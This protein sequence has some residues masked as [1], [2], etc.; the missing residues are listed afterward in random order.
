MPIKKFE[1]VPLWK[2]QNNPPFRPHHIIGAFGRVKQVDSPSCQFRTDC[3]NGA[4]RRGILQP[5]RL[6]FHHTNRSDVD[7][8]FGIE[9]R[10]LR[11]IFRPVRLVLQR[12]VV[13][14]WRFCTDNV[15]GFIHIKENPYS[16]SFVFGV[17][18]IRY[19]LF[20]VEFRRMVFR[21]HVSERFRRIGGLLRCGNP[22]FQIHRIGRFVL[23]RHPFW[24]FRIGNPKIPDIEI[25]TANMNK[26]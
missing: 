12:G 23:Y 26:N 7:Q 13:H 10:G 8:R 21:N 5:S 14:V 2:N 22:V 11:R 1:N 15:A 4:I 3:G 9:Q 25:A 20:G 19:F 24:S 18:G 16:E 6:G 17:G